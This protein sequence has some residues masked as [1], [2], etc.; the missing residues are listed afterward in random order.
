MKIE[1]QSQTTEL[2]QSITKSI[3]DKIDEKLIPLVEENKN[4]KNKVEKLEKEVEVMKRA[5]KKNNIVVFGLE[6]KETST[7]ELLKEFKKHLN[8][9]LNIKIEDYEINKIYRLGTKNREN[10]KPRPVLCSFVSNWRKNE[11]IKNKKSLI[12][13]NISE[14]YSKEVLEKRKALQA[15]LAEEKKKGNVAY[16]KYD[17]LVVIEGKINQDKRKREASTSP[18]AYHPLSPSNQHKKQQII[19][20]IKANRTNVFDMMRNR[21]NSLSNISTT[22]KQ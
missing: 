8:Q 3:M 7:L 15:K 21:S 2:K 10:N 20:S 6:E 1:M 13:I 12:K 14:D 9:D 5:E 4:L 17:K 19:A 16:L 18:T 11:I 22:G